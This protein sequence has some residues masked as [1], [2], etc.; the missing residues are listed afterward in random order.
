MLLKLAGLEVLD[1]E[2]CWVEGYVAGLRFEKPIHPAVFDLL[3]HRL[4]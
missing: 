4:Q 3:L 1:A 2:T